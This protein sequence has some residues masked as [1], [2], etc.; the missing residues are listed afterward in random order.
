MIKELTTGELFELSKTSAGEYL[1]QYSYPFEALPKIKEITYALIEKYSRDGRFTL[2]G[3]GILAA[4]SA[5]IAKSATILP[6][7]FIDEDAEIRPSAYIR[8]SAIIGRGAVLGNSSEIKNSIL[9][10][11]AKA[12]HFN[13]IGDSILGCGSHMGAGA[14]TSNLKMDKSNVTVRYGKEKLETGLRKFGAILGDS[15]EVGCGCVLNPGTVIGKHT[16]V[17]PLTAT[18]GFIPAYSVVKD[19]ETIVNKEDIG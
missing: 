1:A 13:Y 19:A 7:T 5:K 6:P 17:Y 12:P 14:V 16:N 11:G 3:E 15:V 2:L 8:G 4:K 18:R 9:F 10:D